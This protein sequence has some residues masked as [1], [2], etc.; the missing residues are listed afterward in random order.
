MIEVVLTGGGSGLADEILSS[1]TPIEADFRVRL[2]DTLESAGEARRFQGRTVLVEL[3]T[4]AEFE[5]ADLVID[6][7]GSYSGDCERF[8]PQLPMVSLVQRLFSALPIDAIQ[9]IHGVL[10][11]PAV[12]VLG[13]VDALAG[14][15]TQLFNGR[16]PDVMPFGG[17]LA[18]NSR[19]LDDA[20]LCEELSEIPQLAT[21]SLSI[22]RVQ[23]DAFYT[24]VASLWIQTPMGQQ[25]LQLANASYDAGI[26]LAPD[27]GRVE[28]DAPMRVMARSAASGWVHLLV[29]ADLER[30]LWAHDVRDAVLRRLDR[31]L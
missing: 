5:S 14:Q 1:L 26:G 27:S 17:T 15:V 30:T 24:V 12:S 31:V 8:R 29:S 21:A 6:L 19:I 20:Q 9:A 18:F 16:D 4:E 13:G 11:E 10:R 3:D 28:P 23:S 7:D 22:E 2:V 25:I